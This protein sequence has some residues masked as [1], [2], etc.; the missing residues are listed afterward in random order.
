MLRNKIVSF[1]YDD[2]SN[3]S[4]KFLNPRGG[5]VPKRP[6]DYLEHIMLKID[7]RSHCF[8]RRNEKN[9]CRI[10]YW[11]LYGD[12]IPYKN[13]EPRCLDYGNCSYLL[14]PPELEHVCMNQLTRQPKH[15]KIMNSQIE[16]TAEITI[17]NFLRLHER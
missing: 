3:H 5:T 13:T 4:S 7:F 8:A 12:Y 6:E 16:Q 2:T 10:F 11:I 1:H 9:F 17:L 14:W 15:V